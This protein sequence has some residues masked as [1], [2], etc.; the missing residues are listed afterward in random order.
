MGGN[1]AREGERGWIDILIRE[2]RKDVDKR[3]T[4]DHK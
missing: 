2:K 4:R 1:G 3:Q